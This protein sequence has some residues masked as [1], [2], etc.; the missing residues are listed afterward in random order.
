[1][2]RSVALSMVHAVTGD[3]SRPRTRADCVGGPRPCPWFGCRY[4]LAVDVTDNGAL[5]VI[6]GPRLPANPT[7]RQL[8]RFTEA[9]IARAARFGSCA[10][11]KIE[12]DP[13][14]LTLRDIG[15][16]LEVSRERIRQIER[17]ALRPLGCKIRR[18]LG[19]VI[20]AD[21]PTPGNPIRVGTR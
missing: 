16:T 6:G 8:E 2:V 3:V 14:G 7:D 21:A 13:D 4:H 18:R 12:R 19:R 17:K 9:A 20:E 10:L 11:D 5:V 1:M 15:E